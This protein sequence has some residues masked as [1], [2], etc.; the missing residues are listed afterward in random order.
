MATGDV[1][2]KV[3]ETGYNELRAKI[4]NRE[5]LFQ[6]Y[7]GGMKRIGEVGAQSVTAG[8]PIGP[9]GRTVN[10]VRAVAS[11]AKIPR[12]VRVE[13]TAKSDAGF[14]Y[15]RTL[16]FSPFANSRYKKGTNRRRLWMRLAI[17]RVVPAFDQ[18][19]EKTADEVERRWAE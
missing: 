9:S 15:P 17:E 3:T 12:F 10:N 16:E 5:D 6:P 11:K 18:I 19:F 4:K 1:R 8:A 13:E 2:F 7:Q 14:P